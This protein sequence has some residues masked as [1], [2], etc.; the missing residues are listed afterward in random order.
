ME[1]EAVKIEIV[2]YYK[3][4]LESGWGPAYKNTGVRYWHNY[5]LKS[6]CVVEERVVVVLG[7]CEEAG[8][9]WKEV[10]AVEL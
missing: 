4:R 3:E 8:K 1:L 2:K 6:Q 7:Y 10:F 9:E 5:N